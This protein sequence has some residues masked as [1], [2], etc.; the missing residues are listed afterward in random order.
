MKKHKIV[1]AVIFGIFLAGC[2]GVNQTPSE[3]DILSDLSEY[4]P[5]QSIKYADSLEIVKSQLFADKK[6][7]NADVAI[8]ASDEYAQMSAEITVVYDY[9]DDKGWMIN[10][11]KTMYPAFDVDETDSGMTDDD[12][13]NLLDTWGGEQ[14]E[15]VDNSFDSDSGIELIT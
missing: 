2:G 6:E 7:W 10:T 3:N 5:S 15:Y 11:E 1:L 12:I 9:Y 8:S 4:F 13:Q 14:I